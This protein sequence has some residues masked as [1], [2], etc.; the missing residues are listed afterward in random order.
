MHRLDPIDT[1]LLDEFQRG[2]PLC[3]R[4]FAVL[5]QKLDLTE[6]DVLFRLAQLKAS[7]MLSRVGATVRPNVAGASTLAAMAV[8]E[9]RLE[10]VAALV[11]DEPGVNHSYQ[12]EDD[13]NLWFVIA[14]ADERALEAQLARLE[15]ATGLRVLDLRLV[16]PFN[17]DLGFSLTG[18]RRPMAEDRPAAAVELDDRDRA[19]LAILSRDGLRF[20]PQPFQPLAHGLGL[21]EAAL[22]AR[23]ETFLKLG[24]ITRMGLIVRHRPLGWTANAM[25]VWDLPDERIAAAGRTLA[26]MPGVTLCYQRRTV[27]GVWPYGLYSMIHGRSRTEALEVLNRA[28][29]LPEMDGA[30]SKALFSTRCFKQTGALI[31]EAA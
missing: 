29:A 10:E 14:A 11:G 17:I 30:A 5:S 15:R 20:V 27:P 4:P 18:Q 31:T 24:V 12:R 22:F 28:R 19:L 16:R 1:R 21:S 8:P 7:G 3:P 23:L 9:D 25:V 13:W 2:F 6:A 26:G